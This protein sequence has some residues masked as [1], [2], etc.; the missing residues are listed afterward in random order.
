MALHK[1]Q[2]DFITLRRRDR[3]E[4]K[5]ARILKSAD[6]GTDHHLVWAKIEGCAWSKTLRKRK[7][8]KLQLANLRTKEGA[9]SFEAEL[10]IKMS[11]KQLNW[12][13]FSQALVATA[14]EQ[15]PKEQQPNKPWI[16]SECWELIEERRSSKKEHFQGE[17]Y[18]ELCK[19]VTK[20]CRR[21]KR[22]WFQEK[23][24]EAEQAHKKGNSRQVLTCKTDQCAE[25]YTTRNWNQVDDRRNDYDLDKILDRWYEHG[26][27]LYS[28]D[29]LNV[30]GT[31]ND[32]PNE[33]EPEVVLSE[34][35]QA[36]KRL[37]N[38]KAPGLDNIPAELLKAG[39]ETTRMSL[40]ANIDQIWETGEWPDDWVM[41]AK[42]DRNF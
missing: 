41:S 28:K 13:D 9:A 18:R 32:K 17:I 37:K 21:A 25:K 14:S 3:K 35:R 26:K 19:A 5:D 11:S 27:Q 12:P 38:N 8:H 36:V 34:I 29:R 2:I 23:A 20:C 40:K 22:K 15:C 42:S 30:R 24:E 7:P 33:Q 1:N 31:T 10:K 6:C 4:W 39:G 16:D